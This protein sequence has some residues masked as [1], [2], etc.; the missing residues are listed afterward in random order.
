L[1]P[2][3]AASVAWAPFLDGS[4]VHC[5][6]TG[7]LFSL[8]RSATRIWS[9]LASGC[10]VA[11]IARLEAEESAISLGEAEAHVR[12]LTTDLSDARLWP[13]QPRR[14]SCDAAAPVPFEAAL[15]ACYDVC[16]VP[17][18]LRC[19]PPGLA[20][21][22]SGLLAPMLWSGERVAPARLDLWREPGGYVLGRDGCLVDRF[23]TAPEARWGTV[24][25]LLAAGDREWQAMLHASAVAR[26]DACLMICGDSGSGK[27]TLMAGLL[28]GGLDLVTDDVLPVEA[29]SGRVWPVRLAVSVKEGSWEVVGRHIPDLNRAPVSR[30][31]GRRMRHF[32]PRAPLSV[33]DERG[34]APAALVF[35]AR[36]PGR[37][38]RPARIGPAKALARLGR[39]GSVLPDTDQG[40]AEFLAWLMRIPAYQLE[41]GELADAVP[42]VRSLLDRVRAN[43]LVGVPMDAPCADGAPA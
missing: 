5:V 14:A 16:G 3:G 1:P 20:S 35:P 22:L 31:A 4:V 7:R 15:D 8:N 37:S 21:A 23:R 17:V 36:L 19:G 29:G 39:G 34:L 26:G 30:F 38:A 11:E 9:R 10:D 42:V 12:R 25:A 28:A 18:R 32:W 40:M 24:R 41:Y 13:R 43:R 2:I 6:A 33:A 27:T